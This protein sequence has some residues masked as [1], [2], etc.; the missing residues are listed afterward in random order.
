MIEISIPDLP[1]PPDIEDALEQATIEAERT[2][3]RLVPVRSGTLRDSITIDLTR[4]TITAEADYAVFVEK[5]TIYQ[6]P[7][8]FLRP[9]AEEA[10]RSVAR[11]LR[12]RS[13]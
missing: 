13:Q 6:A 10:L 1:D 12:T 5:G 8:P 3:N 7:Q 4:H 2:A 9:A 11:R